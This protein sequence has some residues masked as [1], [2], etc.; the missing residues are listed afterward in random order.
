[1]LVLGL[2]GRLETMGRIRC[3]VRRYR[4]VCGDSDRVFDRVHEAVNESHLSTEGVDMGR[5]DGRFWLTFT[6]CQKGA[7]HDA[8]MND[9]R[10]MQEVVEIRSL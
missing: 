6:L 8:L 5:E 2:L 7:R 4:V 3:I 10:G 9:L 1:M